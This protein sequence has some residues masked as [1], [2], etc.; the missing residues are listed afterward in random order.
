MVRYIFLFFLTLTF[1]AHTSE[2]NLVQQVNAKVAAIQEDI[3]SGE[4][5][6]IE[7]K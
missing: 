7:I 1:V 4:L 5:A 2:I 6:V 3:A